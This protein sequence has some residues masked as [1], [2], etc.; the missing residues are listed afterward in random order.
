MYG[1][2]ED[3]LLTR[4]EVWIRSWEDSDREVKSW[5]W[6]KSS[7]E[8]H[9]PYHLFPA[10]LRTN[11]KLLKIRPARWGWRVVLFNNIHFSHLVFSVKSCSVG[12]TPVAGWN[13]FWKKERF[14]RKC[15]EDSQFLKFSQVIWRIL[16]EQSREMD[17]IHF[18]GFV[19]QI[20]GI[21]L[22]F[23][24]RGF[25]FHVSFSKRDIQVEW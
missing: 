5:V 13:L 6:R 4:Q 1:W 8:C 9:R 15:Y 21:L 25:S 3:T 2:K 7:R 17:T 12:S 16:P 18:I 20:H 11:H 23:K 22:Y 10:I 24:V 19:L 14:F